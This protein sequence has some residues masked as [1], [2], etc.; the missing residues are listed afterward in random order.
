M[1]AKRQPC[2][3]S[4]ACPPRGLR[5]ISRSAI[6]AERHGH[7]RGRGRP[8]PRSQGRQS[9][10]P[11]NRGLSDHG[12]SA[13]YDTWPRF[14]AASAPTRPVQTSR[15]LSATVRCRT[16]YTRHSTATAT[17]RIALVGLSR[18]P[19][20][21]SHVWRP[22]PQR[23]SARRRIRIR[24][25]RGASTSHIACNARRGCLILLGLAGLWSALDGHWHAA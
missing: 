4:G 1:A 7:P 20:P 9:L 17:M 3:R 25:L 18:L 8:R 14:H 21:C 23:N 6:I 2:I 11:H 19:G 24:R 13:D 16:A 22:K 5:A 15:L 10:C 12:T